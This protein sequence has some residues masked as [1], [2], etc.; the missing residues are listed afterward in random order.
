MFQ[1]LKLQFSH[2]A[3]LYAVSGCEANRSQ[4]SRSPKP[5]L[6]LTAAIKHNYRNASDGYGQSSPTARGSRGSLVRRPTAPPRCSSGLRRHRNFYPPI[7]PRS[8]GQHRG[9]PR[10]RLIPP[11]PRARGGAAAPACGSAPGRRPRPGA[12]VRQTMGASSPSPVGLKRRVLTEQGQSHRGGGA[13]P[14]GGG[15]WPGGAGRALARQLSHQR[16]GAPAT[17]VGRGA[18]RAPRGTGGHCHLLPRGGAERGGR[19]PR[20]RGGQGPGQ[21]GGRR[22]ET[23]GSGGELPAPAPPAPRPR[24]RCGPPPRGAILRRHTTRLPPA[25]AG[26]TVPMATRPAR[27]GTKGRAVS[28]CGAAGPSRGGGAR[29][30]ALA[31]HP[32][33][34]T[35]HRPRPSRPS[36]TRRGRPGRLAPL[37]P[38]SRYRGAAPERRPA[39]LQPRR[40]CAYLV[41]EENHRPREKHDFVKR[42]ENFR[43]NASKHKESK[44]V[45]FPSKRF[46]MRNFSQ[47]SCRYIFCWPEL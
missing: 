9:L 5:V 24:S 39:P 35:R 2:A 7:A 46:G 37:R 23:R 43:L 47:P 33:T 14:G 17:Q 16:R 45:G 10:G 29:P 3:S 22:A 31:P 1:Q 15:G 34:R 42:G 11:P 36:D 38:A 32:L 13:G 27:R 28:S 44:T 19:S 21:G 30:A 41:R 25:A 12:A 40:G 6:S 26:G 8:R 20:R 18:V 4:H